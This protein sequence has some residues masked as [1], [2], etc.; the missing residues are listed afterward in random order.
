MKTKGPYIIRLS[1]Q[2]GGVGKTTVSVNLSIALSTRGYKVLLVDSDM[3]NPSVTYYL[4]LKKPNIGFRD[5]VLNKSKILENAKVL[6]KPTGMYVLPEPQIKEMAILKPGYFDTLNDNIETFGMQLRKSDFD[7]IIFD[8]SPGIMSEKL[9]YYYDEALLVSTPEL[10]SISSIIKFSSFFNEYK[11][12]HNLVINRFNRNIDIG[13]VTELYGKKPIAV[14]PE[15]QT[16]GKSLAK[17]IPIFLTDKRAPF[18]KGINKLAEYYS[19]SAA[20]KTH[21]KT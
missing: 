21:R 17:E 2:K 12:K 4:G 18:V 8:T 16:V 5:M 9:L 10:P 11:V 20:M 19:T 6:Y 14:L 1:S 7:F 3:S 15:D 13:D